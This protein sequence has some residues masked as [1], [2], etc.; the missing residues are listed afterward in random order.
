LSNLG[1]DSRLMHCVASLFLA[2]APKQLD[3]IR[4]A[5]ECRNFESLAKLAH[6]LK[7]TVSNFS[8]KEGVAV[9]YRLETVARRG[10]L[11]DVDPAYEELRRVVAE[12][13]PELEELAAQ[14]SA[15]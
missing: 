5:L 9:A 11:S 14:T 6:T 13:M 15:A 10:D 2:D 8:C 3:A 12:L 7:G 4:I 1:G